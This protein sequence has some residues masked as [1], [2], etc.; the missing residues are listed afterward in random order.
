[1]DTFDRSERAPARLLIAF[2]DLTRFTACVMRTEAAVLAD[3]VDVYYRRVGARVSSSGGR[4]VKFIGD[5]V[6]IVFPEQHIDAGVEALLDIKA[7]V[8]AWLRSIG[9]DARAIVKVHVGTPIA[10]PFGPSEVFDVIG[11]DVNIS[12]TLE[13]LGF[14]LSAEAFRA[15]SPASR[16]RFKKHTPPVTYIRTE[17]PHPHRT[18]RAI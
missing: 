8:D 10:G 17:D 6:L 4:V 11:A 13:S 15:L 9:W 3:I 1:M 2:I 12:A 7:E 5:A 14:A 16:K 18:G